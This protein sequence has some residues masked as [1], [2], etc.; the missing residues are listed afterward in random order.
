MICQHCSRKIS[1]T[2]KVCP[3]CLRE[4]HQSRQYHTLSAKASTVSVILLILMAIPMY[5]LYIIFNKDLTVGICLFIGLMAFNSW[6]SYNYRK[7]VFK[8]YTYKSIPPDVSIT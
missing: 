1:F 4:T 5:T 6:F 8:D 3:N 2:A 7:L